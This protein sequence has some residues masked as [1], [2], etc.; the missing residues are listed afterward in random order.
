M[1][2]LLLVKSARHH[3]IQVVFSGSSCF[4]HDIEFYHSHLTLTTCTSI[5]IILLLYK[6]LSI[7]SFVHYIQL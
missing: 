6:K 5:I 1:L 3:I 4:L 2:L 7:N